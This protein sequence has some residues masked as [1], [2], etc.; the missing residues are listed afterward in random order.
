M[1]GP[2]TSTDIALGITLNSRVAIHGEYFGALLPNVEDRDHDYHFR[3]TAPTL[4]AD[5]FG[6]GMTYRFPKSGVFASAA[7]GGC[8]VNYKLDFSVADFELTHLAHSDLGWA[9]T[10]LVGWE[11][12]IATRWRAG[13]SAQLASFRAE[14]PRYD[15]A[16]ETDQ[17]NVLA[18]AL[19]LSA[20][21]W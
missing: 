5:G 9:A 17:L 3:K 4:D 18:G 7:V 14:L 13:L 1:R 15:W 16:D 11:W 21:Y 6:V 12:R 8:F 19:L 10:A 2:G 20:T